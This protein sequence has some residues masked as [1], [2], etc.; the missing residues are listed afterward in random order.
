MVRELQQLPG[1]LVDNTYTIHPTV[2]FLLPN[3]Y[4]FS[5]PKLEIHSKDHI[6]SLAKVYSKY[7]SFI[8]KHNLPI[9]CIC[10]FSVTCMWSPCHTCKHVYDEYKSYSSMLRNIIAMEYFLKR[11]PFDDLINSHIVSYL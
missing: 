11:A 9:E 3:N 5:P 4:P 10:C 2:I 6:S 7:L 1:T 8:K